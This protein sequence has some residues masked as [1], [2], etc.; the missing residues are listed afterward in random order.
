M[1]SQAGK[2]QISVHAPLAAI[3]NRSPLESAFL[4]QLLHNCRRGSG[5]RIM[6]GYSARSQHSVLPMDA[7]VHCIPV[8][9][10]SSLGSSNLTRMLRV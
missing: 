5:Q 1:L 8:R 3:A 2:R 10:P 6:H 9:A 4:I 7:R